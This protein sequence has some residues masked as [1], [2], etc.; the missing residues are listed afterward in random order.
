MSLEENYKPPT[1]CNISANKTRQC[2][3]TDY[4]WSIW[5]WLFTNYPKCFGLIPGFA[6]PTGIVLYLT[7]LIIVAASLPFVRRSGKFEVE[8]IIVCMSIS[9]LT[10]C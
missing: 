6:N 7:L 10:E 4:K 9:N 8:V 3:P 5:V 2:F 1:T